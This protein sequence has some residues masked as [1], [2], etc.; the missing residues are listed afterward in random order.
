MITVHACDA[1]GRPHSHGSF[2][3]ERCFFWR[4]ENRRNKQEQQALQELSDQ[5]SALAHCSEMNLMSFQFSNITP[6]AEWR[7]YVQMYMCTY[8]VIHCRLEIV[9][10]YNGRLHLGLLGRLGRVGLSYWYYLR[11]NTIYCR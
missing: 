4:F 10:S 7:L 8:I 3:L 9:I 11:E 6:R 1:L 2:K 5:S